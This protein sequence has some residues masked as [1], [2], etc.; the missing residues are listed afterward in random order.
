M[1]I[2]EVGSKFLLDFFGILFLDILVFINEKS[3]FF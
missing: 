2:Y 1:F 3:K